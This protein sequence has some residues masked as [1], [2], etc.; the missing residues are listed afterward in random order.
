MGD[1][2]LNRVLSK[3]GNSSDKFSQNIRL[4][5]KPEIAASCPNKLATDGWKHI[6][7]DLE[8]FDRRTSE[9]QRIS[10]GA[11]RCILHK[12]PPSRL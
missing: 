12:V 3:W 6:L 7:R 5:S 11:P 1:Q 8:M 9:F 10:N 2:R 4:L